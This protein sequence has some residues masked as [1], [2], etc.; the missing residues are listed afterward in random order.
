MKGLDH[1]QVPNSLQVDQFNCRYLMFQAIHNLLVTEMTFPASPCALTG[2]LLTK[3]MLTSLS[4]K[5]TCSQAN[6]Y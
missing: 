6:I 4:K 2:P 5:I 1:S 3:K